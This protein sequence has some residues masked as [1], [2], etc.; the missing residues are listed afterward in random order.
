MTILSE[1]F[2]WRSVERLVPWRCSDSIMVRPL[3]KRLLVRNDRYLV[4][5]TVA[6]QLLLVADIDRCMAEQPGAA[7]PRQLAFCWSTA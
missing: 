3:R 4:P 6:S 7:S 1:S 5:Q 2:A